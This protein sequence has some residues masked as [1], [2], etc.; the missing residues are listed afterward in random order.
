MA[1]DPLAARDRWG[2]TP[3][4]WAVVN[5]H[6]DI[7]KLLVELGASKAE[8]DGAGETPLEIA[9]RRAQCGAQDR[10]NGARASTWGGIA[11]ALG[12][13][14]TTQRGREL[15]GAAAAPA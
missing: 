4:H 12:G 15:R 9:E 14:G 6:G 1:P 3:L 13:A 8:R 7:V 10:P 2:R 11:R 5:G